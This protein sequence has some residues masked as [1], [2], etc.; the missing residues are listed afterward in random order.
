M[1]IRSILRN[2]CSAAAMLAVAVAAVASLQPAKAQEP[3]QD[4]LQHGHDR[5]ARAQRPVGAA[6][7]EDL[8]GGHQRQG[9]SARPPRQAHLLRRSEQPIDG[10]RHLLQAARRRQGRPDHRR[11]RHQ[12]AGAGDAARH[13]AQEDVHRAARPRREQRVPLPQLLRHDPG[14]PEPKLSFTRASST[15]RS[16]RTP[17]RRRWRI[18][19]ADAEFAR[20]ACRRRARERQAGGLEDRLRQDLSAADRGLRADRARDRRRPIPTSW[21]SAPIRPT[22]SAW[23]ARSTRSAS[24]RR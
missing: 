19:S 10:A 17:S 13:P 20:N 8:G 24:S 7:A 1:R 21:S 18:V 16:R 2:V 5:R 6:G 14:G 15:S 23:C 12:H 11:L 9:R 22:P 4:R 3:H